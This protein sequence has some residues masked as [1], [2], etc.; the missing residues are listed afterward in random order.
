MQFPV[1]E[2]GAVPEMPPIQRF[3]HFVILAHPQTAQVLLVHGPRGWSLPHFSSPEQYLGEVTCFNQAVSAQLGLDVTVLRC[4]QTEV[5]AST[6][7][8]RRV[9][10]AENH[11]P[12]ETSL[13]HGRWFGKEELKSVNLISPD[14]Q[15]ILHTWFQDQTERRE[16]KDGQE[17]TVP[18]WWRQA[19]AWIE[20]E[21]R[22][23]GCGPIRTIEQLKS[24]EFSCVLRIHTSSGEFYFKAV[25]LSLSRELLITRRLA[26]LHPQYLPPLVAVEPERRWFLMRG[27]PGTRLMDVPKLSW[28]ERTAAAYARLQISWVGR[29]EEFQALECPQ[30]TLTW[31]EDEIE[32]LLAD[33]SVLLPGQPGGLSEGQITRLRCCIPE[34]KRICSELAC[35]EVPAALDHGDLWGIN[36]IINEDHLTFIDWDEASVSHPFFSLL[37]FLLSVGFNEQLA[38]VPNAQVRIRD[39]YLLPW[40][41][42][43]AKDQL[44]R[45]FVL[46]QQLAPLC[47]AARNRQSLRVTK[48]YWEQ[49]EL[50]IPFFL[51]LLVPEP[52]APL[53]APSAR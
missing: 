20:R 47:R 17:W 8:V 16:P 18:G 2:K 25:P 50:V 3:Q 45:I 28:W 1:V 10:T 5:N 22:Q 19:T 7:M 32:P 44:E 31:L 4:L 15:A 34:F 36:I 52:D 43:A 46:S 14:H 51:Q 49:Q 41:Q 48:T 37:E 38:Q 13:R 30:R 21:L 26:E 12:Y 29:T 6:N 24:W 40:T 23:H 27:V 9:Y 35:C 33:P 39:A 42:Y 53:S 11:R